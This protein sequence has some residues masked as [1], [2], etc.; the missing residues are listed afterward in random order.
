M[1]EGGGGC[2]GFQL[3]AVSASFLDDHFTQ[4]G[5][6]LQG[7][8]PIIYLHWPLLVNIHLQNILGNIE[9]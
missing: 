8:V 1:G 3:W 5:L 2:R 7:L 4:V 9:I 6:K